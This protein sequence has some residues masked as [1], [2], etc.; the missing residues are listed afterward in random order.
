MSGHLT[1]PSSAI[2]KSDGLKTINV[3]VPERVWRHARTMALDSGMPFKMY[4][5][6]VLSSASRIR[7]E[8]PVMDGTNEHG[9]Q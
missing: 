5:A 3:L 8:R 7:S 1:S 2:A 9:S 6:C 4:V